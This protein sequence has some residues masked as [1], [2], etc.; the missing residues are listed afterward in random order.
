MRFPESSR[1]IRRNTQPSDAAIGSG[2]EVIAHRLSSALL[3]EDT[4]VFETDR[5]PALD[6]KATISGTSLPPTK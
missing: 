4:A 1:Y 3:A 6:R 2:K 5:R